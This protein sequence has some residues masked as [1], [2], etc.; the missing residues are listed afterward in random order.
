MGIY[1]TFR[2]TILHPEMRQIA[3]RVLTVNVTVVLNMYSF[4]LD[5]YID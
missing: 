5:G 2:P 4:L 1:A 3:I